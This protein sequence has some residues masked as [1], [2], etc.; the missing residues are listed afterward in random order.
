MWRKTNYSLNIKKTKKSKDFYKLIFIKLDA[1]KRVNNKKKSKKT[2]RAILNIFII[3]KKIIT[4]EIAI[5]R[6][7]RTKKSFT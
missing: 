2:A 4:Q 7:N 3:K 1:V 5:K 6:K